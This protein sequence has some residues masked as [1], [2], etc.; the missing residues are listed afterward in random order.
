MAAGSSLNFE[1]CTCPTQIHVKARFTAPKTAV[2]IDGPM[3]NQ[4]A[5]LTLKI[6]PSLWIYPF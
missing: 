2:Q 5:L 4:T 6:S 3:E 1:H